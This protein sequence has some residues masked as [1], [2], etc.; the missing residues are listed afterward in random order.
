MS[1]ASRR[2]A[3]RVAV[4]HGARIDTAQLLHRLNMV[5]TAACFERFWSQVAIVALLQHWHTNATRSFIEGV[6][7]GR[8]YLPLEMLA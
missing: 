7:D 5:Y 8:L 1:R 4:Q 2:R 3:M 6:C